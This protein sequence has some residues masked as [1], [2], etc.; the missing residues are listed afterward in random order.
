M[1]PLPA[2]EVAVTRR[3]PDLDTGP[4]WIPEERLD[5]ETLLRAYTLGGALAGDLEAETGT[6]EVGKAADLVVLDRDPTRIAPERI[7]GTE[8]VLTVFRGQVVYRR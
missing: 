3:D 4:S 8:A 1:D 6:L 7:S 5:V 2:I